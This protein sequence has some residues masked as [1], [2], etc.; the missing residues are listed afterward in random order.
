M[1]LPRSEIERGQYLLRSKGWLSQC[2]EPF[3]ETI[4]AE[5]QWF[6]VE[7][8]Y[9][10]ARGGDVIGGMHGVAD[11]HVGLV[12]A[13]STPDAGLIHLDHA[14]FWFGLQ[15]FVLGSGRQVT[16]MA[17]SS[18]IVAHVSQQALAAI[19]KRHPDGW[20]MLLMQSVAQTG[21][22]IQAVADLLLPDRHRRLGA[23]L[24]RLAGARNAG[25][26]AHPVLC[27]HEELAAMSNLSRSSVA[28]VLRLFEKGGWVEVSYRSITVRDPQRL[29]L[30]VDAC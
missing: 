20:R 8:G 4:L 16:V 3:R 15:P 11:G 28:S 25:S 2:E 24:L 14:P 30:M 7:Q 26:N 1:K 12:P 13:I 19:L 9:P 22:A 27:S 17:R 18:C 21:V 6:R 5:S 29:R 23:V 10:I